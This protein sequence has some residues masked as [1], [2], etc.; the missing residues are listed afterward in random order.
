MIN[1]KKTVLAS[2]FIVST[3]FAQDGGLKGLLTD[4]ASLGASV[5]M[6]SYLSSNSEMDLTYGLNCNLIFFSTFIFSPIL[7]H[8]IKSYSVIS[9]FK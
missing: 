1:L 7:F 2:L 9:P 4:D 3:T 5:G 6:I 8:S